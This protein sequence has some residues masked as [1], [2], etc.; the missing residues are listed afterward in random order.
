[1]PN[2]I[3]YSTT[4]DTLSIKMG[5]FY[6]GTGDVGKGPT[7]STS[8]FNGVSPASNSYTVYSYNSNQSSNISFYSTTND[9]ELIAYTNQISGQN[10]STATQCLN[11]YVTQTN[12]ICVNRDYEGIVTS[13]LT[14]CLDAGFTPSYTTSGITWYDLSYNGLNDTL[15]NGPTFSSS[16]GGGIVFDGTDDYSHVGSSTIL[17]ITGNVTVCSWVKP[18]LFTNQGNIVAKNGNAGY[19][20]RFQSAGTFWMYANG[21]SITSPLS[22]STNNWYHAV[23]VFSS[24]GLRMYIN[25]SLVQSNG[26]AFS[27][28]F[29]SAS[30]FYVG[31]L[32]TTSE[33]FNGTISIINVYNRALSATEI[34]Q[35]FNAQKSRFGL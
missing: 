10:F 13:G 33:K 17:D 35:N 25:G 15:F 5:N 29:S 31:S 19:R 20:M 2:P 11:W 18:S 27:P 9:S 4:G 26:N 8:Y 34:L 6:F 12:Y 23:G 22:Y 21:N 24:T 16:N 30:N 1:M 32:N 3:K 28:N 7:L 14:L